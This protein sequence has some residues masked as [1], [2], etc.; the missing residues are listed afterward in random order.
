MKFKSQLSALALLLIILQGCAPTVFT[1]PNFATAK[2]GHKTV[3]VLPFDVS[4][5]MKK[6]PKG[7]TPEQIKADEEKTAFT[8]QSQAYT[9]LL[10]QMGKDK[11]TVEFQDI[12]KTNALLLK[13]SLDYA[14]IKSKTK[15]EIAKILGVDA[16]MSG[17]IVMEKPMNEGAAIALGLLV[18]FWGSTN[19]VNTASTIHTGSDG[20]LLWKY[21]W[22][23]SGSIGSSTESLTKALMK[24]VSKNFPYMKTK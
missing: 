13:N 11:Y 15:D 10:K 19:K 23:A 12:D 20:K 16:V 8:A 4:V 24:N 3:A 7:V 2:R 21:D 18:G 6:L 14:G 1:A 9:Y 5:L 17:K 22:E